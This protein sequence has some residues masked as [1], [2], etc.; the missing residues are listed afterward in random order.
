MK[1]N[2]KIKQTSE[3]TTKTTYSSYQL[4]EKLRSGVKIQTI[5]LDYRG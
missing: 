3:K 2:I 1:N 4:L 5:S